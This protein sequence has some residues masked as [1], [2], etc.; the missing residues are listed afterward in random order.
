MVVQH[1]PQSYYHSQ[2]QSRYNITRMITQKRPN[3]N[4]FSDSRLVDI[5][6]TVNPL[7]AETPFYLSLAASKNVSE[8]IDIGCGTGLLSYEFIKQGIKVIGVDPF[9]PMLHKAKQRYKGKLAVWIIGNADQLPAIQADI[10][11][12]T[13]HVAQFYLEDEDWATNLKAIKEALKPGGYITFESRNPNIIPFQN[14]PTKL[15][16]QRLI[17]LNNGEIEWWA[18]DLEFDGKHANYEIHYLFLKSQ[19][20]IVSRNELVF[21]TESQIADSLK[22]NGFEVEDIFGDW[23]GS[24]LKSDSEEMIFVAN[25]K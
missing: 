23:D 18:E 22:N 24:E 16:H 5:Y 3:Y 25:C 15:K 12:M 19:Q 6:D 9:Q 8:V 4:E 2:K 7:G 14:W 10:A 17:D 13:G 11:I 21:R 20:E 1:Y